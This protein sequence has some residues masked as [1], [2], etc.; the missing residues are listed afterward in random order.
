MARDR[1]FA[2]ARILQRPQKKPEPGLTTESR[3]RGDT[4]S[5]C[6]GTHS[7][8]KRDVSVVGELNLDLILY[9]L[10]E[11]LQLEREI[12]A[13]NLSITLGS[14][15]AI[16]AHNLALLGNS[17]GFSSS[18]GGDPLGEICLQRLRAS[19]VDLSGV[20]RFPE[21]TTGLSVILPQGKDRYIL[22]YP[23]TM[24][25]MATADLDLRY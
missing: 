9:G 13:S 20:R 21:Q 17:V 1:F 5:H 16:F 14:S 18:I 4:E 15:S 22:T 11:R 8:S 12:L 2:A 25:E 7:M 6:S 19:G 3:P 23:G 24:A 10:P